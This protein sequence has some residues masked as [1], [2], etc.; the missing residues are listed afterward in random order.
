M[1]EKGPIICSNIVALIK[2]EG[3]D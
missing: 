1:V 3:E 2:N